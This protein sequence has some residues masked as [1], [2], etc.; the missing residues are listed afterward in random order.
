MVLSLFNKRNIESLNLGLTVTNQYGCK[1]THTENNMIDVWPKPDAQF[2][3]EPTIATIVNPNSEIFILT[4]KTNSEINSIDFVKSIGS[5]NI[6][7]M[8]FLGLVVF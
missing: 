1:A 5:S 4:S 7:F 3:V 6:S 8:L 2:E